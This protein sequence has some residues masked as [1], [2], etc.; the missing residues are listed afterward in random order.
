M[1]PNKVATINRYR[2][3]FRQLSRLAA[4]LTLLASLAGGA[5][6]AS[7]LLLACG[8]GLSQPEVVRIGVLYPL[9]GSQ[10][11]TGIDLKN[12]IDLALEVV[13]G[14]FDL[15]LPLA[16]S[17]GLPNLGG[18]R[19]ESVLADHAGSADQAVTEMRR[20]LEQGDLTAW[21]GCYNSSVTQAASQVAEAAGV[22]FLNPDS[23]AAVLTERGYR[24]FFRT[25]ADDSI[26]VQNF[27]EFLADVETRQGVELDSAAVVY[28]NSLFGTG[29]AQL[30]VE[31]A[32]QQ[33]MRVVANVPYAADTTDV[34]VEV[35]EIMQANP[36]LVMQ[37][38]YQS[39]AILF[40]QTYK[41]MGYRP[42]ALLAMDAGFISP[43]FVQTLG[44]DA[45]YVLSREV[46]APDI[47]G[48]RPL[49][50]QVNDLYRE[51]YGTN[52][53]GNSARSFTGMIVL[54]DAINRAGSTAPDDI[55]QALLETD[56]PAEQLIMPWL[57]VRFDQKT[58]QNTL[59][60]GIIVQIQDQAYHTVWPWDLASHDLI[61]PM[62][63][64]GAE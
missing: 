18:A 21:L 5:L 19:L 1:K 25:T 49:V 59:A 64:W 48:D 24:W 60:R 30:E 33:G 43:A 29:V 15:D 12:G 3:R 14:E 42:E 52:L 51:R 16:R 6:L 28:E 46:W 11:A 32:Q 20:L 26:F 47:G 22:P 40:M 27:F 44:D 58:G 53:T 55:R 50:Q 54:A 57:G 17:A 13:N 4:R 62:P 2:S 23:T 45:N 34:A 31:Q 39:D 63:D 9:S 61:W 36:Q 38:S 56:I 8:F 35:Q 7:G 41:E 37:A 10:E